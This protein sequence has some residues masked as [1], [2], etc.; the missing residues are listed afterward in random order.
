MATSWRLAKSLQTLRTQVNEAHPNRSKASDG[1]IG[2]AAHASTASD[3][4]PNRNGVVCALDLTHDPANGFDAH[5]LAEHLRLN[6]HPNLRYLISNARIAGWWTNWEWQPSSGHT[7]HIHVSVG[8]LGVADGQTYDNYDSSQLWD[9][10][11]ESMIKDADNEFGRWQ[12]VGYQIRGRN[13]TRDEFRKAAVGKT[14]LNAIEI[15]SDNVEADSA[16]RWQE[17]G[18][19]AVKDNWEKQI[20]DLK[21]KLANAGGVDQATKDTINETNAIVKWIKD[22]LSRIFK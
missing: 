17:V 8:T 16:T 6:R 9:I 22:L 15:L 7:K 2:D 14:W 3:H 20:A 19:I 12:K 5:A 10:K 1:T 11:G 4:N 13:L 21:A 18:R